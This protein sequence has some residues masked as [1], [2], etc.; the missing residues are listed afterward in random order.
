[1]ENERDEL[2]EANI[3]KAK[4]LFEYEMTSVKLAV[5]EE[6]EAGKERVRKYLEMEVADAKLEYAAPE[7]EAR[8]IG[9]DAPELTAEPL[10][11][12]SPELKVELGGLPVIAET[13]GFE[14]PE[15]SA[16]RTA[17]QLPAFKE[18][19][20]FKAPEIAQDTGAEISRSV[21]GSLP[22]AAGTEGFSAEV[23][24]KA[25]EGAE[26]PRAEIS[27]APLPEAVGGF[28][29]SLAAAV[30]E[31]QP[32]P[33]IT[34]ET[35]KLGL[36]GRELDGSASVTAELP[37]LP[38]ETKAGLSFALPESRVSV[39]EIEVTDVPELETP[40]L[41]E[42]G[43]VDVPAAED[44]EVPRFGAS[45][46]AIAQSGRVTVSVDYIAPVP[47]SF[48]TAAPA[49]KRAE[50]PGYPDIPDVPAATDIMA[51]IDGIQELV[52]AEL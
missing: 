52:R 27:I 48:E 44:I 26:L 47:V 13:R 3:E 34:V 4:A 30:P 43:G 1:M 9:I 45:V 14:A 12:E 41:P 23:L 37:V 6:N 29:T 31:P 10:A 5:Q 7:L 46:F 38:A 25:S 16:G 24:A 11:F 35:A 20:D 40:A 51:D 19:G 32:M 15:L 22:A 2:L 42:G 28:D 33:D 17:P 8:E 39:G 50:A 36:S 21:A 49:E 18:T